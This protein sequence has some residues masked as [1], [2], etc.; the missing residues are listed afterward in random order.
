MMYELQQASAKNLPLA[1]KS[2]QCVV[3]SPPYW[4]LRKYA[5]EQ[6]IRWRDGS[7]EAFGL[8]P[9]IRMYVDHTIEVLDEIRRVLRDDGV[10]FWN[11]GDTYAANRGYQVVDNKHIDVGNDMRRSI[12]D[13]LKPKDLCL[14]PFRVAI[15]AQD[16]GWW[17]RQVIIWHKTN[18]MP[19]AVKD[20][21]TTGH[22]YILMLTKSKNYY[23]DQEGIK[24]KGVTPAGTKGAKGSKER[25]SIEGVNSR[26]PKYKVYDG[27]R[28]PRTV[29]TISTKPFRGAHF[30]VFPPELPDKCIRAATSP[31][32]ACAECGAP[33]KRVVKKAGTRKTHGDNKV[34]DEAQGKH[35][36][37][38][39]FNTGVVPIVETVGFE[40]TCKCNCNNVVPCKVLDPFCGSG[41]T[42]LVA[43]Q[44][45]R[46]GKGYDISNEYLDIARRRIESE[47]I[48][49][50]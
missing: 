29:W 7:T 27:K 41:T 36:K 50:V 14:I 28:N 46:Y 3:T 2:V 47:A 40:P 24:E 22:E 45:G 13:G 20:R 38:S 42:I 17:M 6:K 1:D 34:A 4:G 48:Q 16:D 44:L 39:V 15:A 32:G 5:G 33:W 12:T 18:P 9:N 43:N 11:I 30:A 31:H 8:E 35:G 25:S 23:W 49:K 37:T 26:P 10:V 21:C 19:E